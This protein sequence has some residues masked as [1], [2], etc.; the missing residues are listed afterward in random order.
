MALSKQGRNIQSQGLK[1]FPFS[2]Q[3]K[4]KRNNFIITGNRFID[5]HTV[6]YKQCVLAKNVF[7]CSRDQKFPRRQ[8]TVNI[9]YYDKVINGILP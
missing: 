2:H 5:K 9:K 4:Q 8:G 3:T 7:L 6:L 1:P